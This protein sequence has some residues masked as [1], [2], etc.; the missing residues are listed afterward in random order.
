MN[1][2]LAAA[3]ATLPI[4]L[5][6]RARYAD[7]EVYSHTT[8]DR[9]AVSL[10]VRLD[11]AGCAGYQVLAS[12]TSPGRPVVT[13]RSCHYPDLLVAWTEVAEVVARVDAAAG[14]AMAGT[15]PA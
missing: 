6:W 15:P 1:P 2:T 13:V 5:K 14:A 8:T 11:L 4:H 3:L 7:R 10:D 9:A 12:V